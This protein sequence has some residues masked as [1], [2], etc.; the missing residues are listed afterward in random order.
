MPK[1]TMPPS[2]NPRNQIYNGIRLFSGPQS[3]YYFPKL[4]PILVRVTIDKKTPKTFT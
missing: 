4:K 2:G 3:I 1:G